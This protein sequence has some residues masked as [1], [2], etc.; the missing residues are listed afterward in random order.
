L[1]LHEAEVDLAVGCTYKYLNGGPGAPAF[2][3]VRRDLQERL[4]NPVWGWF[5]Q[6]APF[7]FGLEYE[8]APGI[9]HFLTGTPATL[10]L[11]A[12]EPVG[13]TWPRARAA[14]GTCA[15]ARRT[16]TGEC[17]RRPARR[18]RGRLRE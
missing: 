14:T 11:L 9:A 18:G 17:R 2:L 7:D 15:R 3:Y 4:V 1:S 13:S 8:P 12:I 16:K 5:G 6:R 10:S